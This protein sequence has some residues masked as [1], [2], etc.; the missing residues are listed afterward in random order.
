MHQQGQCQDSESVDRFRCCQTKGRG[1][2]RLSIWLRK[3]KME[4]VLFA[5]KR[6][7]V[8]FESAERGS[9]ESAESAERCAAVAGMDMPEAQADDTGSGELKAM[10]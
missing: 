10:I 4:T 1:A 5:L 6:N 3:I 8:V 2:E 7:V 9:A